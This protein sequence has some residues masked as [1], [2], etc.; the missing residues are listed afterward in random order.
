MKCC[1]LEHT[2]INSNGSTNSYF[3]I[4]MPDDLKA[5]SNDFICQCI[6]HDYQQNE[7][8]YTQCIAQTS[9]TW[10]SCDHTFKVVANIGLLHQSDKKWEKQ[11]NSMF[12]IL[13]ENGIVL[14][15]QLTK[16]TAFDNIRDL[17]KNL[18]GR[19][20]QQNNNVKLCIIDNCCALRGKLQDVFG[21]EMLVTL[22]L[23]HTVQRAVKCISKRH[24]FAYRC[25][26]AFR[27]VFRDPSDAGEKHT[28]GPNHPPLMLHLD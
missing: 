3:L 5:P 27:L 6:I 15:W 26:Q 13:N 17:L 24:H 16:G 20:D 28:V 14:V 11:Y 8:L 19:F 18:K 22:D 12:C 4:S 2:C 1:Q 25:C 21:T 23:F 9:A 10:I 7:M